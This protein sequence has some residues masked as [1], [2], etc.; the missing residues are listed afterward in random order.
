MPRPWA[1]TPAQLIKETGFLQRSDIPADHFVISMAQIMATA[2]NILL[3]G[4]N[5][6]YNQCLGVDKGN[7][8]DIA[9]FLIF[10][11][12]VYHLTHAHHLTEEEVFFPDVEEIAGV[13]G[14]M[15]SNVQQHREFDERLE[16]FR[17]YVFETDVKD[18]DGQTLKD[19]LDDL[20]SKLQVHLH[21]EVETM[22]DLVKYDEEK[23]KVAWKKMTNYAHE[24]HDKFLVTPAAFG[25]SD[26]DQVI[27][28]KVF[29]YP[30][31][32][33]ELIETIQN[34]FEPK[35]S[36]AW[37]FNPCDTSGTPRPLPFLNPEVAN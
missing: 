25:C 20:L 4:F 8:A 2:H 3:R 17:K 5:S 9:D 27:D 29:H 37:R 30:P 26:S 19:T 23:L 33:P 32:T 1:D 16:K 12:A 36:G 11:Q 18:Y 21:E 15:E 28:G 35:Y 22:L 7:P 24:S 14:L 34:V 10:N 6:S 13:K 31:T